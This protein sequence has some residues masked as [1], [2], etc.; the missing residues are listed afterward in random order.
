[1]ETLIK[2][3]RYGV[4]MLLKSPLYT[5]VAVIALALGIGA[6]TAIF[7]VVNAVLL[8][9]LPYID[10]NRLVVVESG[11]RQAGAQEF[12]G[13]SPAD[14]WDWQAQTQAFEQ[15]A[16]MS[17]GGFSL[18]GVETP[19]SFPGTRVSTNFFEALKA[20]PLLG[21]T[22]RPEDG[23]VK[24]DDTIVLSYRLWQR[25]F[26]ADPDIIGKTLGDTG[27]IVIGVMPPDFKFPVTAECWI[28][29]SRDSGEMRN[30]ANR[31]F[32][33]AGLLKPDQTIESAQAEFDAI[34]SSLESQYPDTNKNISVQ[35]APYRDRMVRDVKTSLLVLLG[36]VMFVLAIA[37]ANVASIL[38]A[39][40]AS[41]RK[42]MAIRLALGAGRWT[43]IRQLLTESVML[44]LAGGAVGLVFALWGVDL[45]VRLLPERY[46]Y[47][48]VQDLV[49]IDTTTLIFTLIMALLTGLLFGLVPAWQSSRPDINE[50]L[51]EGARGTDSSQ[52]RTRSTLVIAEIALAMVLLAG[53]GL[54][55]QSF[56][57]L[58]GSD[59]GFDPRNLFTMGI[60]LSFREHPDDTSRAR[61]IKKMLDEVSTTPGVESVAVTSGS[62]FPYLNFNFNIEGQPLP[63]DASALYETISPNYFKAMKAGLVTGREFDER[64]NTGTPGV[65]IINEKL[66]RRYFEGSDPVGKRISINYLGTRQT[67]EIIAVAR[68]M[69][70]GEPGRVQPQI[71]VSYQQ[72]PWLSASLVVRVASSPDS[73][74][75]DAQQ[76]I[77][78]VDKNQPV[79]KSDSAEMVLSNAMAEPRLHTILLGAFAA[80]ALILA[81]VGI[82][83]VMAYSVAERTREIGIRMALG[84]QSSDVMK[85]VVGQAMKL[86]VTGVAIGLIAAFGLTRLI[87]SLLY[88]VTATDPVTFIIVS[89]LLAGVALVACYVPARRATRIDPMVALR[90]E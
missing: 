71:Y 61:F 50:W 63:A 28:A 74:R 26:G 12:G 47:L 14:F 34:A 27:V 76:A 11:D 24:A 42:E 16:G 84:A 40:A 37:C 18:T 53:A 20:K 65:A 55:L 29:L 89:A 31:Y 56:V 78:A 30:R 2:D 69:N 36:A 44:G 22:F 43:L 85:M 9:P 72:Q 54:L 58:R 35:I 67:R 83:G 87:A 46:A 81:A 8:R 86:I 77:W 82:Y 73:A 19:E 4:R 75:K 10:P 68:D 33:V 45:L 49:R 32:S 3:L 23:F 90:Y 7:S 51:K 79:S 66:A 13:V 39:R 21:R 38:L 60:S 41:R 62:A 1:M 15:L 70:Q 17:G 64:D 59:P 80:L 52:Q 25:R 57:R 88:G 48:Q 6:N 5:A